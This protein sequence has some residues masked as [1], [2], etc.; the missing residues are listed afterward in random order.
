[1]SVQTSAA[2]LALQWSKTVGVMFAGLLCPLW[3]IRVRKRRVLQSVA[4]CGLLMGIFGLAGCGARSIST[5]L[6]GGQTYAL[7]I[8]GTSTNLA[9]AVVSH[10]MRVTLVVE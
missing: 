7:T 6:A 3:M 5:S 8:T 9:G 10:A 2:L 1:M 4:V